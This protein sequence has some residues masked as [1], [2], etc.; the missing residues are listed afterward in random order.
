MSHATPSAVSSATPAA[1]ASTSTPAGGDPIDLLRL[2]ELS[3]RAIEA[4]K[5]AGADA[6]DAVALARRSL[7]V[8]VRNGALEEAESAESTD[9][10]LRAFVGDRVA[11]V[12]L[13]PGGDLAEAAAR[14]VAMA[15]AAPADPT[16]GLAPERTPCGG[17]VRGISTST[18][19]RRRRWPP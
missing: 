15:R 4:A 12:G 1:T 2:R 17:S 11:L 6:A 13:G 10:G 18:T 16:Q 9:I 3:H 8:T 14:V 5:A 19:V 7:S